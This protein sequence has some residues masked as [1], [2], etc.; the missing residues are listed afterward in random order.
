MQH[1]WRTRA[2]ALTAFT[3][4]GMI[5][6]G[7]AI[8]DINVADPVPGATLLFPYFEVDLASSTSRNTLLSWHAS[9]ASALL[10]HV[11]VWTDLGYPVLSFNVYLTG[12]D[13]VSFDLRDALQNGNLPVTA[14]AGQ[15][16]TNTISPKGPYSQDINYAS[17]NGQIPY[18]RPVLNPS[19]AGDLRAVLSGGPASY[20]SGKCAGFNH[21]DAIARGYVTVDTVNNC[22]QRVPGNAGYF[23]NGDATNQNSLVGEYFL[24]DKGNALMHQGEGVAL[25][26]SG[27]DPRT[28]TSGNY[29]FYG[30]QVSWDASDNRE[31][32]PT[33]WAIDTTAERTD[34]IVWR[35]PKVPVSPFTC[36]TSYPA[37]FPLGQESALLFDN[38]ELPQA[39]SPAAPFPL[40]AQRVTL[41]LP[42]SGK[43]AWAYLGL[44][45]L[46]PDAGSVPPA[47]Q[48][49]D[50]A[51]V[52]VLQYPESG[53]TSTG[54][55]AIS[56]DSGQNARHVHP[57]P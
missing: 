53:I 7:P 52:A 42:A 5:G 9:G 45:Y 54:S 46:S 30:R 29:T 15:D 49:A 56:L 39:M 1:G 41:G 50:Q 24:V 3:C 19:Y 38:Q 43:S 28:S 11:T 14:S 22:T 57:N 16:P 48:A 34:A 26:A 44:S 13:V 47:D 51:Y 21:G 35:D 37:G 36:G 20:L 27:S 2:Y 18:P 8:A 17:C 4:V 32:L 12:Y 33:T 55:G 25:E 10:T 40:A 6:A 23:G 31:P